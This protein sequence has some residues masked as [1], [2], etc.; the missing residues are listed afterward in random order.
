[1]LLLKSNENNFERMITVKEIEYKFIKTSLDDNKDFFSNYFSSLSAIYDNFLEAHILQSDV[2]SI[3]IEN[4]KIGYFAIYQKKLLTQFY[5]NK[6]AM[7]YAQSIFKQILEQYHIERA[8]VPTCDELLLSM[9]LD[10]HKK[11]NMQ[12][13]FFE[14]NK[15]PIYEIEPPKYG[16]NLLRQAIEKDIPSI[17]KLCEGFFDNTK[18]SILLGQIYILEEND[19][20]LG[21]GLIE[22]C[23]IFKDY[24]ATGMFTVNKHRQNGVGRSIILHLKDICYEK[25]FKPLP[26][27]WYYNFNSKRTL[28]SCGYISKTRLLNIEF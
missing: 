5:V 13:Y 17:E 4:N 11:V 24:K 9:S 16:R 19:N 6:S 12:A 10:F 25:G 23:N 3:Y 20:I 8:F 26:G 21:F 22:D 14:E 1:M 28:E 7:K 27:C 2:Y 15:N 18:D